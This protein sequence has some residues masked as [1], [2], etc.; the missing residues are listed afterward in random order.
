[1]TQQQQQTITITTTLYYIL[2]INTYFI[3]SVV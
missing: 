1:M 3:Q 2:Y